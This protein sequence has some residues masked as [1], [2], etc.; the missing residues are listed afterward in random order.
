M[1]AEIGHSPDSGRF[2]VRIALLTGL[3]NGK[4]SSPQRK[5]N[6]SANTSV[7][8]SAYQPKPPPPRKAAL[9]GRLRSMAL[10]QSLRRPAMEGSSEGRPS[11]VGFQGAPLWRRDR[12]LGGAFWL[13]SDPIHR[14]PER[15]GS[16]SPWHVA[17]PYKREAG[18]SCCGQTL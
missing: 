6:K 11:R 14:A 1:S 17:L 12:A 3:S 5:A 10:L 9:T 15:V 18:Q 16:C 13:L 8:T 7:C 4:S 2:E